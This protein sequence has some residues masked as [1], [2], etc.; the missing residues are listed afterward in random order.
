[1]PVATASDSQRG[2]VSAFDPPRERFDEAAEL[3]R[4]GMGVV[5]SAFDRSLS[6][7][8][9]IKY[10]LHG[11]DLRFEREVRITA[12]LQ[13]PG[14]V[15]ILD[16]GRDDRGRPFYVMRK[17]AG[18]PLSERV[19]RL[20][21]IV[22]RL[23][24]VPALLG[25]I[26][27]AAYAHARGIVHRDIKPANILLGA[28]GET[29]LI[30]WGLARELRN[31]SEHAPPSGGGSTRRRDPTSDTMT[32]LGEAYGTPG[33]MAPEQARGEPAERSSDVYALGATLY[34]VLTGSR[35]FADSDV[36]GTIARAAAGEL[37]DLSRIPREVP[38]ELVSIVVKSLS[39]DAAQ[40]YPDAGGLASDVRRFL[41]GQLVAAY[42]YTTAARV[43]RW[44]RRHRVLAVVV[45]IAV[46]A[47]AVT[48]VVAAR[49]VLE[50]RDAA[51]AAQR[52]AELRA[53]ELIVERARAMTDRDPTSA[54]AFLAT[55]PA[56]S[57][58]WGVARDVVRAAAAGS[59][60]RGVAPH[61]AARIHGLAYSPSGALASTASDDTIRV[62]DPNRGTSRV[63]AHFGAAEIAWLDD[64]RL[65]AHH[66][67]DEHTTVAK[68]I[69]VEAGTVTSLATGVQRIGSFEQ[70]ALV[71]ADGRLVAHAAGG[72]ATELATGVTAF[73]AGA[74]TLAIAA[75]PKLLVRSPGRPIRELVLPAG[76]TWRIAVNEDDG[77]IAARVG[78]DI[79]EWTDL[80][81]PARHWSG[82][83][84]VI[85]LAYAGE[86]LIGR[87]SERAGLAILLPDGSIRRDG[88]RIPYRLHAYRSGAAVVSTTGGVAWI[89]HGQ[90]F[91]LPHRV[92]HVT[93]STVDL[94]GR[95][96][97]VGTATGDI[98]VHD[99]ARS[100]PRTIELADAPRAPAAMVHTQLVA[101]HG[102]RALVTRRDTDA[103]G[104]LVYGP[105]RLSLVDLGAGTEAPLGTFDKPAYGGWI[106][107]E[108]AAV[109]T[110]TEALVVDLGTGASRRLTG[111]RF[112][113]GPGSRGGTSLFVV[114]PDGAVIEHPLA[115]LADPQVLIAAGALEA[116]RT[117]VLP[118][119]GGRL[120]IEVLGD[121][122]FRAFDV[123]TGALHPIVMPIE[124]EFRLRGTTPDGATWWRSAEGELRRIDRS[125]VGSSIA[126]PEPV[127]YVAVADDQ[128][129]AM[130]DHTAFV[131]ALDGR[132]T[133]RITL[134]KRWNL[135]AKDELVLWHDSAIEVWSART[136]VGRRYMIPPRTASEVTVGH[137]VIAEDGRS[138][139]AV[140]GRTGH[141]TV[142][143][144]WRDDVPHAPSE[145]RA[146]V[147]ALT[148][149]RLERGSDHVTF[150]P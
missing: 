41:A 84:E 111:V 59:V 62:H 4:G 132:I 106:G 61:G 142:I 124:G 50:E 12:R 32:L 65:L 126:V 7:D 18:E 149:A 109:W 79:Y 145:V 53:E 74:T 54:I 31:S 128:V 136:G 13:H 101:L 93:A 56:S 77:R 119:D 138:I 147:D 42:E 47:I 2:H 24:L 135:A 141:G 69:D 107:A 148:N 64:R 108:V 117:F 72:T 112:V 70:Q 85:E 6:R 105:Q 146:Y 144:V 39:P 37:P 78:E 127:R 96:V 98:L 16:A 63:V 113:D 45:A 55:L 90:V 9:A 46:I 75:P 80:P 116:V 11:D 73:T 17:I 57:S 121:D 99:L 25:A 51:R 94:A 38:R 20:S 43:W 76:T 44:L 22:D 118:L 36:A 35:L 29:L 133:R 88:R 66:R 68:L 14:V 3:G 10:S 19:E 115:R 15:P 26:D 48:T 1:M 58:Q 131:L 123:R 104:T 125:G 129:I 30:D 91:E 33:F 49:Q 87:E 5:V 110:A 134:T 130:G 21:S 143:G 150:G 81:T 92:L 100:R 122:R 89:D 102:A 137:V 40:R 103:D 120:V 34:F 71:L 114:A 82:T 95:A 140:L 97:A 8:V 28:F 60:E 52:A 139:A 67:V 27:A 23:A 86:A 83:G